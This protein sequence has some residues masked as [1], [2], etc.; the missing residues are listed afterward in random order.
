[1][2][3][4]LLLNGAKVAW[5]GYKD[6]AMGAAK[7]A[8]TGMV[9]LLAGSAAGAA[10]GGALWGVAAVGAI[11][12]WLPIA[13]GAAVGVAVGFGAG[14][15]AERYW[16]KVGEL[17]G[18][19]SKLA[20]PL[21]FD[22][23]G[24]GIETLGKDA[25]V[26][27]DHDGNGFAELTGWVGSN[28]GLLVLDR[29]GNGQIDNGSELFGDQ[30]MLANGKKAANGFLALADFDGNKDKVI[31]AQDEIYSQLRIWKDTNSNGKADEGELLTLEEA[32]I[33]SI[34]LFYKNQRSRGLATS[35]PHS[36]YPCYA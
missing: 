5:G 4:S 22:L 20:S 35:N 10:V 3:L 28:D 32:G 29:D 15:I 36:S 7:A 25:G 18:D 34:N 21:V 2:S 16:D 24:N 12:F 1:M 14:L 6:G 30:S 33:A 8:Y 23:N 27:F 9:G 19:A 17:F 13:A 26:H 31:N 11:P